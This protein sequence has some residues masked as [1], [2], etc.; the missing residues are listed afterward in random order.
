[1]T[2]KKLIICPNCKKWVSN[3]FEECPYCNHQLSTIGVVL[4]RYLSAR[5]LSFVKP[6][7]T[8][9]V[10]FFILSYLIPI[11]IP[12]GFSSGRGLLGFL[13][14]PSSMALNLL[15]WA[16][17]KAIFSG[18]WWQLVTGMFLHGGVLHIL[19]NMMWVK[20]LAPQAEE[21]FSPYKMLLIYIVSGIAGNLLA[22]S[23]PLIVR[24]LFD[25]PMR[26]APVI[27]AS[28]AVFG[29]MGS[30]IAYG[31]KRG[32]FLGQQIA[33]QFSK[34]AL[35]IIILGFL[36]P[37]ISNAAHIGGL[38]AGGLLGTILPLR[39]SKEQKGLYQGLALGAVA[40]CLLSFLMMILRFVTILNQVFYG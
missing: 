7:I 11:I 31:R 28:G 24:I 2:E 9:N 25:Y 18:N 15:G 16:D 29:L 34:W 14:A 26:F 21:F 4:D 19:F 35:V 12:G 13:P 36:M 37:G 5:N 23:L 17:P 40:I 1:M 39:D 33:G 30:M 27:G 38:I 3:E 8:I 22:V 32:G 20:E 10:V 6:I